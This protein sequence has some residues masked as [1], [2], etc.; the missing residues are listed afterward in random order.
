MIRGTLKNKME[1][2]V[3]TRFVCLSLG[4]LFLFV[5]TKLGAQTDSVE[6][7]YGK[8]VHAY[9]DGKLA[10]SIAL[11]TQAIELGAQ[12]PRV[13]YFRGVAQMN[14]GKSTAAVSDFKTG[15]NLEFSSTGR[16]YP[17]N[18]SLE[19]VQGPVRLEIESARQIA[20]TDATKKRQ[21]PANKTQKIVPVIP[22][23]SA[24]GGRSN[25]PDVSGRK[26]PGTPFEAVPK[27]SDA[28]EKPAEPPKQD[29]SGKKSEGDNPF[30]DEKPKQKQPTKKEG[31]KDDPFDTDK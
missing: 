12:D 1:G 15:A 16:Y 6:K 5:P 29:A 31:P 14:M 10:E 23:T 11:F 26:F 9:N 27:S 17:I 19:R 20:R 7:S 8:G 4:L 25:F 28:N 21:N 24:P 18:R 2:A 3:M 13:Y 30:K 22:D